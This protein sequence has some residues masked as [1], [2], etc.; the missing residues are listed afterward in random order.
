MNRIFTLIGIINQLTTTRA[1]R[2]LNPI[3]LP[4]AQFSMLNHFSHNPT[5]GWTVTRLTKAFE[6]NQPAITKTTQRLLKKG[7]LEVRSEEKD[8]RIKTYYVTQA[9][10][11]AL[12]SAWQELGK[13]IQPIFEEWNQEEIKVLEKLL[14][15]LKVQLDENR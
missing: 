1:N 12:Q 3:D 11:Q 6:M 9:G 10:L 2:I 4:M 13:D 7:Y 5:R 15:Q 8:K 14:N